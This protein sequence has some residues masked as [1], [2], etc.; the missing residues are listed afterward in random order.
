M[1]TEDSYVWK[2]FEYVAVES[3]V[4]L[5][6]LVATLDPV[7]PLDSLHRYTASLTPGVTDLAGNGLGDPFAWGFTTAGSAE[8]LSMF[9]AGLGLLVSVAFDPVAGTLFLQPDFDPSIVEVSTAGVELARIPSPGPSSNDIDL[10]FAD[11]PTTIGATAVP[12]NSLLVVNGEFNPGKLYAVNRDDGEALDSLVVPVSGNPVGGALR[13]D[14]AAF[15]SVDWTADVITEIDLATG[16]VASSFPVQPTG[17]P[18]FDVFYGDIDVNPLTGS[19]IV[20]S[21]SQNTIRLLSPAGVFIE[22][23]DLT[24]TGISGMSG[25]AWDAVSGTAWISTTTG[26][27]YRVSGIE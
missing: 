15:Y 24:G 14:G 12:E 26:L 20:V 4:S 10:D 9:D 11:V 5:S 1:T 18:A 16:E 22:D 23:I 25:I 6:G 3:T 17:S 27:V 19:I 8:V 21:S 7:A 13:P 2:R